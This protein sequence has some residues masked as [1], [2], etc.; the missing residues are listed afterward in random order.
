L[1]VNQYYNRGAES[2]SLSLFQA[3][4]KAGGKIK[5][6]SVLKNEIGQKK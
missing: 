6:I 4:K 5:A 1:S 2:G 3:W